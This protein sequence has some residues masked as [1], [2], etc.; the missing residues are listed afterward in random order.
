MAKQRGISGWHAMR[1]EQLVNA[2]LEAAT[3]KT[4]AAKPKRAAAKVVVKTKPKSSRVVK[5][6]QAEHARRDKM[7][8]LTSAPISKPG[9]AAN[10]PKEDRIVLMVRDPYWL[11]TY[12][13]ITAQS[14]QRAKVALGASWHAAKP[15]IR[16]IEK[17]GSTAEQVSRIIEIHGAV[18]NW[19]IDIDTPHDYRVEI[20][21]QTS[22]RF[23]ALA[24]SNVVTSPK[25]GGS[26][27]IDGNWADVVENP[28]RIY[29]MSGGYDRS[30]AS[31]QLQEIL[32][33]RL[34]RPMGSPMETQFG[35]GAENIFDKK[36]SM[37][38]S[39]D[40]EMIVFG[41]AENDAY[42]TM[43]GEP[44]QL[45]PDGTFT[46]RVPLPDKRQV[47]PL[48]AGR[49]DGVEQQ[50]IVLAIERNTKVMEPVIR[51]PGA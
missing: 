49:S 31:G 9:S 46:V 4:N 43:G 7:R 33:E 8:D 48:V 34:R 50:T 41:K 15:V 28:E 12:W 38:F 5:R 39:I 24:K 26:E 37:Q 45:G 20:G 1:K 36:Q 40:A 17:S 27:I 3:S 18:R 30:P 2:L 21:Y 14:V 22:D 44:V 10:A 11:H 25:P 32:E 47:I 6:I 29:A 35:A 42:V 51:E 23:Y 16:L 19:Y 13:E